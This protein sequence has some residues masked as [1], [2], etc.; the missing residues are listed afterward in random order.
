MEHLYALFQRQYLWKKIKFLVAFRNLIN[1]V[2]DSQ[3]LYEEPFLI[4]DM[5]VIKLFAE[6]Q[7]K[8][9]GSLKEPKTGKQLLVQVGFKIGKL[10]FFNAA[11]FLKQYFLII[12]LQFVE[13]VEEL[14]DLK[15]FFGG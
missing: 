1:P 15:V 11:Q 3:A 6:L 5:C 14:D 2:N 12:F 8:T 4:E 7:I 13:R 9:V 10:R